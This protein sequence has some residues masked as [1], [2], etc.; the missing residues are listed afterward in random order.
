MNTPPLIRAVKTHPPL[1]LAITWST[2][3]TLPVD[4]ARLV[5]RLK[6][7]GPLRDPVHFRKAKV[8]AWGHAVLWPAMW[9]GRRPALRDGAGAGARMGP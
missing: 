2:G 3:E 5:G 4:V 6:L 7:Y 1:T 9:T 8:D